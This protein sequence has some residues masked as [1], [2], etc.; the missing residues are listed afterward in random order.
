MGDRCYLSLTMRQSDVAAM[1]DVVCPG[2]PEWWSERED[3]E[4]GSTE[5]SVGEA[6]YAWTDE[7]VDAA[8]TLCFYGQHGPGFCYGGGAFAACG[9]EFFDKETSHDGLPTVEFNIKT[10][11][12]DKGGLKALQ[13]FI[14]LRQ[15]AVNAVHGKGTE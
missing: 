5:L 15:K 1:G 7:L 12:P 9:G 8:K 6:N 4:D 3:N 13:E 11:R 14:L 10:G 2:E